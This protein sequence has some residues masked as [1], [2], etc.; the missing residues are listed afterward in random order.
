[1]LI[2]FSVN[3]YAKIDVKYDFSVQA[4]HMPRILLPTVYA[5][6]HFQHCQ[7]SL[8][9][10][11]LQVVLVIC[12]QNSCLFPFSNS[13]QSLLGKCQF[14]LS[15][16]SLNNFHNI[17]QQGGRFSSRGSNPS[18]I[19]SW[20]RKTLTSN[21]K[22]LHSKGNLVNTTHPGCERCTAAEAE[23]PQWLLRL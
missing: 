9:G 8:T 22:M 4:I 12:L 2:L 13:S 3:P 23:W 15:K 17:F 16:T 1:M 11:T 18:K 14:P 10:Q 20:T 7:C 19:H 6:T 21:S 5:G